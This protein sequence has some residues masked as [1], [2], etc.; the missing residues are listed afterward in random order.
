MPVQR[1]ASEG[2]PIRAV[3]GGTAP[4]KGALWDESI[5]VCKIFIVSAKNPCI[6]AIKMQ[7]MT[8]LYG[9]RAKLAVSVK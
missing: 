1:E 8:L 3:P 6:F 5:M 9:F 7:K 2:L 4:G